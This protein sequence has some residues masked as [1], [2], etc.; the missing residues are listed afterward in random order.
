MKD[1]QRQ[2]AYANFM[3]FDEKIKKY[4]K[5]RNLSLGENTIKEVLLAELEYLSLE[6]DARQ[7]QT[8]M[9][10]WLSKDEVPR[11]ARELRKVMKTYRDHTMIKIIEERDLII[12]AERQKQVAAAEMAKKV[13]SEEG[14]S[15]VE[16]K[17]EL[18][19]PV[20]KVGG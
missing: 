20:K 17:D 4:L 6:C 10:V 1:S 13:A 16:Y 19:L 14:D 7:L 9:L 12:E 18:A 8:V 11:N 3:S 2:Y 15:A 5:F